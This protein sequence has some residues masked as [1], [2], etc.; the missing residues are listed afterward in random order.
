MD[1]PMID[2]WLIALVGDGKAQVDAILQ[3]KRDGVYAQ[4]DQSGGNPE[5]DCANLEQV[6]TEHVNLKSLY[7]NE[8]AL[9]ASQPVKPGASSSNS[10]TVSI[11]ATIGSG[12]NTGSS[13]GSNTGS[14]TGSNTG[15]ST[16]SNTS[17]TK[18]LPS[19]PAFDYVAFTKSKLDPEQEPIPDECRCYAEVPGDQYATPNMILQLLP[20]RK[21]R[22]GLGSS[23]SEGTFKIVV[24]TYSS[25]HLVF[26]SGALASGEEHSF[27]FDRK[28]GAQV[29]L[30]NI[31]TENQQRDF[32]CNQRGGRDQLEQL[33]FKRK[34]PQAGVF[35]CNATDGTGKIYPSKLEVLSN[36]RYRFQ[37][38]EGS[39]KVN[40]T[41]D[42]N[43]SSSEVVFS[44]GDF[45]GLRAAYSEDQAGCW[46]R[47]L[48]A[49]KRQV[50][51]I[52][53]F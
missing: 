36:R 50:R 3:E 9:I 26:T 11:P 10:E 7:P 42:H 31:G 14:S 18:S 21:Y 46:A 29:L 2:A 43:S 8:Y 47:G 24:T 37:N 23:T 39:F 49:D 53:M 19:I 48:M 20:G 33:F 25:F 12:V 52:S 35:T 5:V 4:L 13:T 40:I 32:T 34:D 16:G 22:V 45:N 27:K 41:G 17:P 1:L 38:K 30:H 28:Q 44:G 6:L 15:S 51:L